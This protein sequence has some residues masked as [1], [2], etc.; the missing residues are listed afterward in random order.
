MQRGMV[1]DSWQH[2]WVHNHL[3]ACE[4]DKPLNRDS[5]KSSRGVSLLEHITYTERGVLIW[6]I[7]LW[8]YLI[9]TLGWVGILIDFEARNYG[10]LERKRVATLK[11]WKSELM[12]SHDRQKISHHGIEKMSC[13][14][15]CHLLD[16]KY[17]LIVWK[18]QTVVWKNQKAVRK[19][20]MV[21]RKCHMVV[22]KCPIVHS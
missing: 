16:R 13:G 11:K 17:G 19:Y 18:Y 8:I 12:L 1:I 21:I 22:R 20:Q 4:G 15:K 5:Y 9:I 6:L 14:R 2:I 10:G 7:W 3:R